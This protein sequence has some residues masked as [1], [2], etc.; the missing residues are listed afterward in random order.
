LLDITPEVQRLID[1]ALEEDQ[2]FADATT[3]ALIDPS[4]QAV[5]EFRA[6]EAGTLAGISAALAVFQ[7]LRPSADTQIFIED[8]DTLAPGQV[9]ATVTTSAEV[10][11]RGERLALNLLQRMSGIATETAG[12]VKA[13]EGT[14]AR[15]IDTRK[16]APG[17]RT[18]DKYAVRVGGG[19]NHR[20]HLGDGILIKDN[21][22]YLL[23]REAT[24]LSQL[25]YRARERASH[26]LKIEVEVTNLHQLEEALEGHADIVLLDNMS[27]EDMAEA[28]RITGGRALLEASGGITIDNVAAVA[29]TGVDLI[30]VGA[31]THSV[32]ALDISMDI[33]TIR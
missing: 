17:L 29:S 20:M 6:E 24:N 27:V 12:Y 9:I 10:V 1:R 22:L 5:G 30:S 18:L 26:T 11:L 4:I 14:H 16:T 19:H 31:L 13:V 15:I 32:K 3:Q 23:D 8:G 21:H 7:R 33:S 2:A 25:I 28:V